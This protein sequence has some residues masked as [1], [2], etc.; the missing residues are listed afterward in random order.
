MLM[1]ANVLALALVVADE[2]KTPTAPTGPGPIG[3][4]PEPGT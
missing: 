1:I 2:P 3:P 4:P